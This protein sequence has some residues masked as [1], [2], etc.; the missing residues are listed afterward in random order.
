M[1]TAIPSTDKFKHGDRIRIAVLPPQPICPIGDRPQVKF[2]WE[3]YEIVT[4][5]DETNTWKEWKQI[6]DK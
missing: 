2:R 1:L 5:V 4:M 6:T 3:Y